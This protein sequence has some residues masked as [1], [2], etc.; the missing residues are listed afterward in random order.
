MENL[1]RCVWD[2]ARNAHK[3]F[4]KQRYGR[5]RRRIYVDVDVCVCATFLVAALFFL[6]F[7]RVVINECV[8]VWRNSENTIWQKIQQHRFMCLSRTYLFRS[9]VVGDIANGPYRTPSF[10]HIPQNGRTNQKHLTKKSYL[11]A[12]TPAYQHTSIHCA[13]NYTTGCSEQ[14]HFHHEHESSSHPSSLS[15][16]YLLMATTMTRAR[17]RRSGDVAWATAT[18]TPTAEWSSSLVVSFVLS[19][20]SRWYTSSFS[21]HPFHSTWNIFVWM[22][23][24]ELTPLLLALFTRHK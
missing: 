14:K 7:S 21:H 8:P 11:F 4:T 1:F 2:H 20:S 6:H 18:A 5:Y 16:T 3:Q 22:L 19:L 24:F 17:D 10:I 13:R 12:H 9:S 15:I 23:F